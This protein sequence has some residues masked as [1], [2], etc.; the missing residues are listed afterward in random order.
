MSLR[1]AAAGLFTI[2][3]K[4][5]NKWG[6]SKTILFE[7][8][9]HA[10]DP[11]KQMTIIWIYIYR[12]LCISFKDPGAE[13]KC[14]WC[15][16]GP[17]KVPDTIDMQPKKNETSQGAFKDTLSEQ[18][19]QIAPTG[20][21]FWTSMY[22]NRNTIPQISQKYVTEHHDKWWQNNAKREKVKVKVSPV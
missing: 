9:A 7:G 1:L 8:F 14:F 4:A 2:A 6:K 18:G 12:H 10:A 16:N 21:L 17:P 15:Q 13:R 5:P 19:R 20:L 22:N 3:H 11:R